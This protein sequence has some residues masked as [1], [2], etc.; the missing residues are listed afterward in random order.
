MRHHGCDLCGGSIGKD[1][2]Y[3]EL[4]VPLSADALA[5]RDRI[6]GRRRA[7]REVD[8]LMAAIPFLRPLKPEVR[9][10][11]YDVCV[12]CVRGILAAR[13]TTAAA[14]RRAVGL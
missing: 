4:T 11:T 12:P 2:P 3:A 5:L 9:D 7:Q 13:L 8:E 1:E 10:V 14:L 6:E